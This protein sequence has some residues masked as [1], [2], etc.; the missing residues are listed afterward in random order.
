[1]AIILTADSAIQS[2][3]ANTPV[4]TAIGDVLVSDKFN[5]AGALLG[6]VT[7]LFAGGTAKTWS[8]T[9]QSANVTETTNGG[10]VNLAST[11]GTFST[12]IDVGRNDF[13]LSCKMPEAVGTQNGNNSMLEFCKTAADTGDTY[14]VTMGT[15]TSVGRM[16]NMYLQKRVGGAASILVYLPE[17]KFNQVIKIDKKGSRIRVYFDD[18]L[19]G[20]YTDASPLAGTFC[21]FAGSSS[22]RLWRV[23]DYVIRSN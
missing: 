23:T 14:R 18:V 22:N 10:R 20:D 7:D 8:G 21:G 15:I 5:R 9:G 12:C 3:P 1:M 4:I 6:S 17:Y 16:N 13:T 11:S 19:V 2:V